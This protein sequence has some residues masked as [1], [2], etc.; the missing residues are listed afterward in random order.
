MKESILTC[1]DCGSTKMIIDVVDFCADCRSYN[2]APKFE[3]GTWDEV[4]PE[5]IEEMNKKENDRIASA[6][7]KNREMAIPVSLLNNVFQEISDLIYD[8]NRKY[9][10]M[11]P[12]TKREYGEEFVS[13]KNI[14]S[15]YDISSNRHEML[16][17]ELKEVF[18]SSIIT[19]ALN[20]IKQREEVFKSV[21]I[22]LDRTKLDIALKELGH[23]NRKKFFYKNDIDESWDYVIA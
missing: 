1:K 5:E 12:A 16:K 4:T 23:P 9:N 3:D 2:V 7:Q 22:E 18:I 14:F 19:G 6:Q 10:Q 17:G 15:F 8:Y 20:R 13:K 11:R 21:G